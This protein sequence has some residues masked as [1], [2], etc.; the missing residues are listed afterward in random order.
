ML[1][2]P[3]QK[4]K[5][6]LQIAEKQLKHFENAPLPSVTRVKMYADIFPD[7]QK[8]IFK[9]YVTV[10]NKTA[11]PITQL[12]LDGDNITD[13]SVKYNG[14]AIAYTIPLFYNRGKI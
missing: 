3:G 7:Q 14:A 4:E 8:A 13:Y 6:W 1:I 11:T 12:L 5:K 9:A 10:V 2:I